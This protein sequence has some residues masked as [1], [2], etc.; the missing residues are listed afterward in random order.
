MAQVHVR[1]FVALFELNAASTTRLELEAV[2]PAQPVDATTAAVL[3]HDDGGAWALLLPLS[4]LDPLAPELSLAAPESC[5]PLRDL[6]RLVFAGEGEFALEQR[7]SGRQ[8]ALV[9]PYRAQQLIEHGVSFYLG[10]DDRQLDEVAAALP[11]ILEEELLPA[12]GQ[13]ELRLLAGTDAPGQAPVVLCSSE[14][15]LSRLEEQRQANRPLLPGWLET[16]RQLELGL[17]DVDA[18]D[19][20]R[21]LAFWAYLTRER[22]PL[23]IGLAGEPRAVLFVPLAC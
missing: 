3:L 13:R 23:V 14:R 16:E 7:A 15:F 2:L 20:E 11:E 6:V 17:A 21:E 4:L 10:R 5:W 19:G 1:R 12:G 9:R 22:R 18:S 8:L